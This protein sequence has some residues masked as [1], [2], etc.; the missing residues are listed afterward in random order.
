MRKI[1]VVFAGPNDTEITLDIYPCGA[2][3]E[4]EGESSKIHDIAKKSASRR[5]IILI[6]AQTTLSS[7][8]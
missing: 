8:D 6:R 7:V 3:V 5:K 1:R 4:I 2:G